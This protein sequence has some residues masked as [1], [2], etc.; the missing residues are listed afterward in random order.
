MVTSTS[1][2][3]HPFSAEQKEFLSEG[4][5]QSKIVKQYLEA[6]EL[7]KPK[8]GR[9]RTLESINKQ[10]NSINHTLSNTNP[11]NRLN[12]IQKRLELSAELERI[13]NGPDLRKL[14]DEFVKV[15]K[16][17]SD[18]KGIT[19]PAWRE[20]GVNPSVLAKAG[21]VQEGKPGRKPRAKKDQV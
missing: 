6:I 21:I 19:F 7:A 10:L 18:R 2:K 13:K 1:R 16:E 14:E 20:L 5:E 11:L 15:A 17:Y 4:R 8:R 12:L 3:R 9:K